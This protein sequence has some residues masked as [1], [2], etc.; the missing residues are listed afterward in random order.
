MKRAAAVVLGALFLPAVAH[1]AVV[2][3][4]SST[5]SSS[6]P[7]AEG[8]RYDPDM[9]HDGK[10]S[11]AWTEGNEANSGLGEWLEV[12]FESETKLVG[13]QIW[14]GTFVSYDLWNRSGR[15]K[16]LEIE[17]SDGTK[18]KYTLKD[19]MVGQYIELTAPVTA[20]SAKMRLKGVYDG[21][22][23]TDTG[24]SEIVFYDDAPSESIKVKSWSASSV[25]PPDADGNYETSNMQD[26]LRDTMWC[27]GDDGDG[28]GQWVEA[29][30]G[31]SYSVNSLTM[32]NGNGYD[33]RF[34]MKANRA[35]E[36]TLTF[37]D[38]STE[39]VVVKPGPSLQTVTFP[40]HS[41]TSVKVTVDGV[42]KGMEFNDLCLSELHFGG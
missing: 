32:I 22:T 30:F 9:A 26:Q 21:T 19:E 39:K 41:T 42:Q 34:N 17:F 1:A 11:T 4:A 38:G 23:F 31:S 20:T 2:K 18:Q 12:T 27:E 14:G 29:T 15:V 10:V 16:E 40:A 25:Y 5:A 13:F 37:S 3:I 8:V 35:K 6:Y 28:S 7:A 33:I 36:L 24:I